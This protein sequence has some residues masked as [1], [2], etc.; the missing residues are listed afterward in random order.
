MGRVGGDL[1]GA[2]L[3]ATLKVLRH[4]HAALVEIEER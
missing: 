2:E 3:A 1:T 4:M